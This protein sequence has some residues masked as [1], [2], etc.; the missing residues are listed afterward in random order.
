M[1]KKLDKPLT[2]DAN[3]ESKKT[4]KIWCPAGGHYQYIEGCE[5]SCKKKS[6][7]EA[8]SDYREPKFL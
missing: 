7:C 8:Y 4:D 3:I 5:A 2:K 1:V 6:R